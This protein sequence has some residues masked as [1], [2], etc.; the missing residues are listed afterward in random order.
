MVHRSWAEP[1]HVGDGSLLCA[2]N[3]TLLQSCNVTSLGL[4]VGRG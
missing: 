1:L 2:G 4:R 3:P